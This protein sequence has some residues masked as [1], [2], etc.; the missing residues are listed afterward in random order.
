MLFLIFLK[1]KAMKFKTFMSL[2]FATGLFSS[3]NAQDYLITFTGS[4]AST[5]LN[6]VKVE[7][8]TQG[9]I[10]IMEG[11]NVLHLVSTVTG[12]EPL[13]HSLQNPLRIYPNPMT[14]YANLQF[15]LRDPGKTVICIQDISGRLI[16]QT[17]DNLSGEQHTY[18][19]E[20][21]EKG[22]YIITA[23]SGSTIKTGSLISNGSRP[24]NPKIQH[25]NIS[26]SQEVIHDKDTKA[27]Q[28]EDAIKGAAE[29]VLMQYTTG[30]RLKLTG[31]SGNYSTV[32]TDII[33]ASKT[34]S[35]DLTA[36]TDEEG[37]NYPIVKIGAQTWMAKNLAYLPSVS[38]ASAGSDTEKHYYVYDYQGTDVNAAKSTSNYSTYGVLYNWPAA[39]NGK[40]S[41][42]TNPS[43]VRGACPTGWHLPSH[44]EW[45]I[46]VNYLTNN[47]YGYEGS[48]NDIAKSLS[49]N[50]NWEPYD[51]L[52]TPGNDLKTNNSTGFSGLPSGRRL[53]D[54]T[55]EGLEYYAPWWS[56]EANIYGSGGIWRLVEYAKVLYQ[57]QNPV[58]EGHAVRCLK[59]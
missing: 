5:S 27:E 20:G 41:S 55:Y 1:T 3:V 33:E 54:G 58:S 23:R 2:L 35:F 39:M 11:S 47:G 19:I 7:N 36:C 52:G 29:E 51:Q 24:G 17:E 43:G 21:L 59:D 25:I 31:T 49:A 30:D 16:F 10:R 13:I 4:G 34:I 8:M 32:I 45:Q 37:N 22:F 48:G 46:L 38:P 50:T 15:D 28:K 9:T 14:E 12:I 56:S 6:S 42:S 26:S 44:A 40:A 53:Y 57:A 18:H